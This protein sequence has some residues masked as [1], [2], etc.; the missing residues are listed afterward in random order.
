MNK[1]KV[2]ATSLAQKSMIK[3]TSKA[4][5]FFYHKGEPVLGLIALPTLTGP[6]LLS[7]NSLLIFIHLIFFTL[8]FFFSDP[9]QSQ[10]KINDVKR[11]SFPAQFE[12]S[13]SDLTHFDFQFKL[14]I[15]F[16]HDSHVLE[17]GPIS[18]S[19]CAD[20]CFHISYH[21]SSP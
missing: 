18:K 8:R 11:A 5:F 4:S 20:C 3:L 10:S 9:Y 13:A 21:F 16:V 12:N 15:T 7:F 17:V 14:T 19:P 6:F 2:M 1:V